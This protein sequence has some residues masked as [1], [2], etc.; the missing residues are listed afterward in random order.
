MQER[1]KL[2]H[3]GQLSKNVKAQLLCVGASGRQMEFALPSTKASARTSRPIK[4][5][6]WTFRRPGSPLPAAYTWLTL[7]IALSADNGSNIRQCK[8]QPVTT[9]CEEKFTTKIM[10]IHVPC[11]QPRKIQT[12]QLPQRL[13]VFVKQSQFKSAVVAHA[14]LAKRL[15]K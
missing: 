15:V 11:T 8:G 1:V 14:N 3:E 13:T 2:S 10:E 12:Y 5:V 9:D 6:N 4:I 7:M